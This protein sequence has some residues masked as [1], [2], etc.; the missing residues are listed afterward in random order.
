MIPEISEEVNMPNMEIVPSVDLTEA[1]T[2]SQA[3]ESHKALVNWAKAVGKEHGYVII[4]QK[5]DYGSDKRRVVMT[6]GCERGGKYKPSTSVLKRKWTGTKKCN[7]PFKLR[8]RRSDKD[9][10]WTVL[11]HSGIHNHDTAEVL[12]GHSYVGRLNLEEKAMVGK[13]NEERVKASDILIAIRKHNP[14]NLT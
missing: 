12:Q 14:T 5:S 8:A 7:C 11:V 3:F 4:I 13:M 1:F 2:T 9:K 6:L 10:M